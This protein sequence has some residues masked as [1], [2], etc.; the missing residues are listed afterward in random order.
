MKNIQLLIRKIGNEWFF[1]LDLEYGRRPTKS[2]LLEILQSII[3]LQSSPKKTIVKKE[4][5]CA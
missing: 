4:E 5:M 1:N 3:S 2:E